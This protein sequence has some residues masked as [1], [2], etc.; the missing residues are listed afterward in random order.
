MLFNFLS[1]IYVIT[2]FLRKSVE[3]TIACLFHS[4]V[5]Y[6]NVRNSNGGSTFHG[7]FRRPE[8]NRIVFICSH[9]GPGSQDKVQPLSPSPTLVGFETT[10]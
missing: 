6:K 7:F 5:C 3:G 8:T 4:Q 1:L 2:V 10:L 9:V